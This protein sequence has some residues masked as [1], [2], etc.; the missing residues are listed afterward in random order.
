MACL[1]LKTR[2]KQAVSS[3]AIPVEGHV[4]SSYSDACGGVVNGEVPRELTVEEIQELVRI[5]RQAA[6]NS[7]RAGFDGVEVTGHGGY[8]IEQ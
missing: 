6:A 3:S 5:Y 7:I 1:A 4:R 2:N 8:L